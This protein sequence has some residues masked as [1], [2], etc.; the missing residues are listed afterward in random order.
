[1]RF[2]DRQNLAMN[3]IQPLIGKKV[4]GKKLKFKSAFT[5][6]HLEEAYGFKCCYCESPIG[7]SAYYDIDHF[8]P[9]HLQNPQNIPLGFHSK[10]TYSRYAVNDVRNWHI[11]CARCN[12]SKKNFLGA[13]SPNYYY[14]VVAK[15]WICSKPSY[16]AKHIWYDGPDAK[17]SKKYRDFF[18]KTL[19]LNCKKNT[20]LRLYQCRVN[21]LEETMNYLVLL[22]SLCVKN[23]WN[24]A[25]FV[26]DLVFTRFKKNAPYS[27]M[28]INNCGQVYIDILE[29]LLRKGLVSNLD[30][31]FAD[32][33]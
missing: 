22:A 26:L 1:M 12:R 30:K 24:N 33:Y 18:Y 19:D 21:Y 23:D 17:C 7:V 28:I 6:R 32:L 3:P 15:K 5:E 14:S 10:A 8:Y 27:Q 25:S 4:R 11:S 16:I 31:Y 2:V 29:I 20:G 13:L 9:Q